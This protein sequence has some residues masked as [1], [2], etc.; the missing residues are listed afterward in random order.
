MGIVDRVTTRIRKSR[1]R[2]FQ[3]NQHTKKK[4]QEKLGEFHIEFAIEENTDSTVETVDHSTFTTY[5]LGPSTPKK[6]VSD[7]KVQDI[8]TDTPKQKKTHT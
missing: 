6:T 5:T 3:G 1:G 7:I 8:L 4:T 2:R